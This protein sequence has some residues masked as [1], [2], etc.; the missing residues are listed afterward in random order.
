MLGANKKISKELLIIELL[1]VSNLA[2]FGFLLLLLFNIKGI[3][4]WNTLNTVIQYLKFQDY[5]VLYAIIISMSYAISLKY[6]KSLFKD[7]SIKTYNKEV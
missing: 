5:M 3:I 2:Y 6:S 4:N 7:S 1:L